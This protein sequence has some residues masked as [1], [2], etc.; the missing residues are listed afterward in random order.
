MERV[1]RVGEG[2]QLRKPRPGGW[3]AEK[4][5]V[6]LRHLAATANVSASVK[7]VGMA[8]SGADKLRKRDP[9]F[10]QAWQDAL[11]ESKEVLANHVVAT[12][13]GTDG[14]PDYDEAEIA[15]GHYPEP[16]DPARTDPQMAL[17]T[18]KQLQGK[19]GKRLGRAPRM[20]TKSDTAQAIMEQIDKV[21]A[22]QARQRAKAQAE[23]RERG[24]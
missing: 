2:P 7:A 8:K 24:A 5:A 23:G 11:A 9:V 1:H 19:A 10:A 13:L 3:T 21:R 20:A 4:R 18:L 15:A 22:R 14:Q 12:H 6:F 16:P 17:E